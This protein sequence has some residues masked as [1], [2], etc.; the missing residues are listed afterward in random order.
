MEKINKEE[1]MKKL[2]LTE[3]ELE[4]VAGGGGLVRRSLIALLFAFSTTSYQ[5]LKTAYWIV[6]NY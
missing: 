6:K 5:P 2:N 3:K 1:L 4:K